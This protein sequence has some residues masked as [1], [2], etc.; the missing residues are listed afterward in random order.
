M[1][2]KLGE[3]SVPGFTTPTDVRINTLYLGESSWNR[4]EKNDSK[5]GPVSAPLCYQ[6]WASRWPFIEFG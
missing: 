4:R 6:S 3:T 5:T 2:R 1:F